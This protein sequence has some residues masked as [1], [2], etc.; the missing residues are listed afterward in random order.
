MGS[1]KFQEKEY[2]TFTALFRNCSKRTVHR[3]I[4][5]SDLFVCDPKMLKRSK[6]N[7]LCE[8]H[9]N[10]TFKAATV[11]EKIVKTVEIALKKA[12]TAD[13]RDT[14][15]KF[16]ESLR[17]KCSNAANKQRLIFLN[18]AIDIFCNFKDAGNIPSFP[19][20]V[21]FETLQTLSSHLNIGPRTHTVYVKIPHTFF[22][23]SDLINYRIV[24][25]LNFA[26]M[27]V[28]DVLKQ[29]EKFNEN[30]FELKS[31]HRDDS[32]LPCSLFDFCHLSLSSG[33]DHLKLKCVVENDNLFDTEQLS[34]DKNLLR[35]SYFGCEEK[36]VSSLVYNQKVI[37]SFVEVELHRKLLTGL[38]QMP[39]A[40]KLCV[41]IFHLWAKRCGV[42]MFIDLPFITSAMIHLMET[43]DITTST[44][45]GALFNLF[46]DF[47]G[48]IQKL[49]SPTLDS[50]GVKHKKFSFICPIQPQ[51]DHFVDFTAEHGQLLK[52][53]LKSLCQTLE[54]LNP[55]HQF[56]ELF[57]R[58]TNSFIHF[59][60]FLQLRVNCFGI[61]EAA[62][63]EE[64]IESN[65]NV[66]EK[67]L[68]VRKILSLRSK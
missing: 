52:Y 24:Q 35:S 17:E 19:D 46:R 4:F 40:N 7:A 51:Y 26:L 31:D 20:E 41:K 11:S 38:E 53:H 33:A 8:N 42:E 10:K 16:L 62:K 64:K 32:A 13:T 23:K 27:I 66:S 54:T 68:H 29:S 59:D 39:I 36:T 50:T 34:L 55:R 2:N 25:K 18:S 67:V 49:L 9:F 15:H 6:L 14:L 57:L 28:A 58:P 30:S 37:N 45:T 60:L 12:S 5:I 56:E 21:Q 3:T 43:N 61:S 22:Y 48:R 65:C 1:E 63:P 44:H 47:C